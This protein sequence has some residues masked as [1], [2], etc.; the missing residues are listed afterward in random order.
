LSILCRH[1]DGQ[2]QNDKSSTSSHGNSGEYHEH[3]T[4][5]KSIVPN[6]NY[7][8]KAEAAK[9]ALLDTI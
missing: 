4:D 5:V 2:A 1:S 6:E 3:V 9:V 7:R 8:H